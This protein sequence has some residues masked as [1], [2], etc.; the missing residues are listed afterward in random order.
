MEF[1]IQKTFKH[2]WLDR[3]GDHPHPLG[4]ERSASY[5]YGPLATKFLATFCTL[6]THGAPLAIVD[7]VVR[8]RLLPH[9]RHR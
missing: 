6:T 5:K 8:S 1:Y 9:F 4:L 2:A 3:A 7:S